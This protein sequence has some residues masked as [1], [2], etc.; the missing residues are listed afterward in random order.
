[1]SLEENKDVVRRFYAEVINGRDVEV[2]DRLLTE[3]FVHNGEDRG[4]EGQK[5]GVQM[6]L[7]A[8]SDL[9]NTIELILAEDDLV[10]AHQTWTG[11]QDGEFLGVAATGRKVSFK[12]TAVLRIRDGQIAE[13]W[14]VVG[15]AEL[16]A[17][18]GAGA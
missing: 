14:D 15:I 5:Q 4:R 6:F 17:E 3:D 8:F 10:S 7:G 9:R 11:T 12:S 16:M 2:I 1:V 13:A 18:L